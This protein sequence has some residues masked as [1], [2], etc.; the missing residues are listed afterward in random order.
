[1][2]LDAYVAKAYRNLEVSSLAD[3]KIASQHGWDLPVW[4][5]PHTRKAQCVRKEVERHETPNY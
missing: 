2:A 1:V 3:L 5:D 4:E